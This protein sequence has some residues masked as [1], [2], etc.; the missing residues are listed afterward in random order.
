MKDNDRFSPGS[1]PQLGYPCIGV[2]TGS[3]YRCATPSLRAFSP[4]S[5]PGEPPEIMSRAKK[6]T[7]REPGFKRVPNVSNIRSNGTDD[8]SFPENERREADSMIGRFLIPVKFFSVTPPRSK[9]FHP[10]G[11]DRVFY[12]RWN[13]IGIGF[14]STVSSKFRSSE[15]QFPR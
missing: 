4:S 13:R 9:Y 11:R 1:R 8:R 15:Y 5:S 2:F 3:L 14:H 10:L 7:W 12:D 6:E